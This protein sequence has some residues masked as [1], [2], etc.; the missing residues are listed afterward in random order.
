MS[1]SLEEQKALAR[2]E[3]KMQQCN[4][5]REKEIQQLQY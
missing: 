5:A 2:E 4:E 1:L 3:S